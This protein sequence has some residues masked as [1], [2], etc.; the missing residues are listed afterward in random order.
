MNLHP[1]V[2]MHGKMQGKFTKDSN[3]GRLLECLAIK[4]SISSRRRPQ[5][6]QKAY[7]GKRFTVVVCE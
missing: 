2:Q 3:N 7:C 5:N 4:T 1:V 6:P